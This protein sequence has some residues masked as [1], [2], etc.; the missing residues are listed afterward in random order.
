RSRRTFVSIRV[1]EL[2][3]M[4]NQGDSWFTIGVNRLREYLSDPALNFDTAV[5]VVLGFIAYIYRRGNCEFGVVLE[6]I[7][8]LVEP[9]LRHMACRPE[10][11]F[12][13]LDSL[14][15]GLGF[16]PQERSER[17]YVKQYLGRA[18]ERSQYPMRDVVVR[19]TV[20]F[21]TMI[22]SLVSGLYNDADVASKEEVQGSKR[23]SS[24]EE[25][26]ATY[27]VEEDGLGTLEL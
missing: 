27:A 18:L 24:P 4:V 5:P 7:E 14:S 26:P 20:Y 10:W 13:A 19:A 6:L 12:T 3:A 11:I 15:S 21:G 2:I 16:G 1:E 9:L 23:R 17:Y 25:I 8:Y 22:P